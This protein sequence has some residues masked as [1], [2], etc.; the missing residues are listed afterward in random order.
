MKVPQME[1]YIVL[2][3]KNL[4]VLQ[5]EKISI[6]LYINFIQVGFILSNMTF[7]FL[8]PIDHKALMKIQISHLMPFLVLVSDYSTGLCTQ[9]FSKDLSGTG[10]ELISLT[11]SP[12]FSLWCKHTG[13]SMIIKLIQRSEEWYKAT[14]IVWSFSYNQ[15]I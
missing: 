7:F 10:C 6:K 13:L 4:D 1:K 8:S 3:M 12:V 15:E 9:R 11:Y 14:C 5:M 2:Q